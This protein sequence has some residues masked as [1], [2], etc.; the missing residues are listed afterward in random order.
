LF[1]GL[2]ELER[3]E[4]PCWVVKA[5]ARFLASWVLKFLDF[6]ALVGTRK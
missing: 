5:R 4:R 1:V 3:K 6:E 2:G